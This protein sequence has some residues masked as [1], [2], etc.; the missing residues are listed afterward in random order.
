MGQSYP[1][2]PTGGPKI[3]QAYGT[4]GHVPQTMT[5]L[6]VLA[7]RATGLELDQTM[8]APSMTRSSASNTGCCG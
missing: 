2:Q 7:V 8:S 1:F 6:K 4:G 5:W 3:K